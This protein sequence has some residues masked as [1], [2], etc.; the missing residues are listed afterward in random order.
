MVRPYEGPRKFAPAY[1]PAQIDQLAEGVRRIAVDAASHQAPLQ[2]GDMIRASGAVLR[3]DV[4]N[5]LAP[6]AAL[7]VSLPAATATD[8]GKALEVAITSSAGA[9]TFVP[10]ASA[11]VN[12][13]SSFSPGAAVGLVRFR[14]DGSGW[15][16]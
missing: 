6:A 11:L 15:W 3:F 1:D 7:R 13:A 16:V 2:T 9:V 8:G 12:G 14:W 4:L 5:R 10:T